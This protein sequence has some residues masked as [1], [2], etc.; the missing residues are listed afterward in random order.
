MNIITMNAFEELLAKEAETIEI[1]DVRGRDA[2]ALG[3]IEGARNI[4]LDELQGRVADL[5]KDQDYYIV[6]Y[7]GN[8]SAIA[9]EFLTRN[10]FKAANVQSGMNGYNGPV[11]S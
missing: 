3:H 6:C 10:G 7:S 2:F 4:P 1:I 11:V 8:F 9:A 5:D